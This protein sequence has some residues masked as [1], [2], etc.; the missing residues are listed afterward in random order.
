M[1]DG[2][3][4]VIFIT[5][6]VA[7]V[8]NFNVYAIDGPEFDNSYNEESLDQDANKND[9]SST[10]ENTNI[11]ESS[12]NSEKKE[13]EST[14]KENNSKN[15]SDEESTIQKKIDT[16]TII[17]ESHV[18]TYG[19][20][21]EK[22]N[23]EISG[24]TGLSKRLEA[25]KISLQNID[26][27]VEYIGYT[28]TYGWQNWVSNGEIAGTVGE[29]K[30]LEAIKIKLVGNISNEYD[31][32]YRV[33]IQSYG[34]LG[35][36]KNGETAGSA[37]LSKRIEAIEIKLV[38]KGTGEGTGNS[39][40]YKK[41]KLQYTSYVQ[42]KG[43]LDY[44]NENQI[45]GTI[46][47]ALRVEAISINL[48]DIETPG[49]IEYQ[50]YIENNGWENDW[51]E[52]GQI[53]GTIGQEKK[54]KAI[55]MRLTKDLA[56]EYDIYYRTHL[57]GF[58]WL[59]WAK[60]GEIAGTMDFDFRVEA[61]EIK[62]VK[63]GT[64]EATGNSEEEKETNITYQAHV[65]SI[66]NQNIVS[67]GETA[68]T[69]GQRKNL[70]GLIINLNTTLTGNI[71]YQSFVENADFGEWQKN[72]ELTGTTGQHKAIQLIK[73][74]LTDQLSE[75]YDIY[76][77]VHSEKYGWLGWAK[78]GEIAG[79]SYYNIQAIEI[80]IH[81]KV[82][83]ASKNLNTNNHYIETGFYKDNN[84]GYIYYKDKYGNNA[85][86]WIS[87]MGKKY[88]FNSLGVM[89]GKDVRKVIDVSAYQHDIDWDKV[90][91]EGNIDGVIVRIAAG[92]EL[93]DSKLARN[94]SELK[95]LNIPYGIYIYSYAENKNE[96]TLYGNFT[97]QMIKKYSLNPT[98]GIY[99]DLESNNVTSYMGISQYTEVVK[100][101]T[102]TL[103]ANGYGNITKIYTY[104]TYA[105][106][107]LNSDY[108]RNQITWIAQYN[109]FCTYTG[110]YNAWQYSSKELIPGIVGNVDASV[111]FTKF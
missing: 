1:K 28:Q 93:E 57:Q 88:F 8:I 84:T 44:V 52:S 27:D 22:Q 110:S 81:L 43:W 3:K 103:F 59:G 94:I 13:T 19:W 24:T 39:Y 87:I 70:E 51:K 31:I 26:G 45:S 50:S 25:I 29:S 46:G 100:G 104:K 73:I 74:R 105:D 58:G 65:Q 91:S 14:N 10:K 53:S 38:K 32:Y 11:E 12:D 2:L 60:N 16:P 5:L 56:D 34:W 78:N 7:I 68:G 23:G 76:Y 37:E 98:L 72:G 111:W 90:K 15:M 54:I 61:Y 66:G 71:E 47:Q 83:S 89:I 95:R 106:T 18:Q 75:R 97:I 63:K 9:S 85:T 108:I 79:A 21:G 20:Q 62:L 17:Y 102:D 67:E 96:G 101:F 4:I 49:L 80:K 109:H 107:A 40:V 64:G 33:H 36:A 82:D 42:K 69:T 86:D 6:I 41:E 35:W 30:R 92:C 77:R 55:R 48:L 99:L